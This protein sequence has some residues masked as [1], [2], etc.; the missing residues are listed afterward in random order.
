MDSI[1]E[2]ELHRRET[3][4]SEL[5]ERKDEKG[6]VAAS[7]L[8]ELRIFKGG[9]GIWWDKEVTGGLF[10]PGA[11]VSLLHTGTFIEN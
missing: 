6:L 3:L 11:T 5:D 9:R 10:S 1:Y 7:D 2:A 8:Q 4:F